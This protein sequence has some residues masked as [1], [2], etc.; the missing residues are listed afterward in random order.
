[1]K[2]LQDV[3]GGL[4]SQVENLRRANQEEVSRRRQVETELENT[5]K[6][7]T[8]YISTVTTLSQSQEHASMSEKRGEEERLRL[9]EELERSSRQNKTSAE[10][11]TQLSAKLKALQQQLLQEQAGGKEANLRN[12]GLYRTIEEKSKA[13]NERSGELQRL[14]E[15]TE[16]QTKERL[17]LEEELTAARHDKAELLRSKQGSD[18]ELSSQITALQLQLQASERSNVDYRNL[19]SELSSEREKLKLETEK[20]QKQATEVHGTLALSPGLLSFFQI[21]V[22]VW[23]NQVAIGVCSQNFACMLEHL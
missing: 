1:M 10:R 15:M 16:S 22:L 8:E 20:I 21:R 7:M 5:T 17:R 3:R 13:L 4:E 14:K 2:D 11:M 23:I 18:D 9:Q 6:A 19:A 12:E